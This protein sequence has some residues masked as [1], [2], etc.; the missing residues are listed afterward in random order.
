[1]PARLSNFT[2][3]RN[4]WLKK[5]DR[6]PRA[7]SKVRVSRPFVA[8]AAVHFGVR[9]R[10]GEVKTGHLGQASA[11]ACLF[12]SL[13]SPPLTMFSGSARPAVTSWDIG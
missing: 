2:P 11:A 3:A 9:R 8:L 1:M 12:G 6:R 7:D 5:R 13:N 10:L 4:L